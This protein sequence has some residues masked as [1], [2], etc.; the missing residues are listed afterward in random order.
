MFLTPLVIDR[1]TAV[2][3]IVK[4]DYRTAVIF[5]KYGISY[6]CG[7]KWPLEMVCQ[8]MEL[9]TE[10][11]IKELQLAMRTI[12][13]SNQLNFHGWP[14]DF[15][16][17]YIINIHHHFLKH[18]LPGLREMLREFAE[19]HRNKYSYITEVETRFDMLA[20]QLVLAMKREEE[21]LFPYIRQIEHAKDLEESY[22]PLMVRT[23][24]KPVEKTL[25]INHTIIV[26]VLFSLRELTTNYTPPEK[27]CMSHKVIL[28]KLHELDNDILHHLHLEQTILFPRMAAIEKQ[29]LGN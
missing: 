12:P 25:D 18:E 24:R 27:A 22:A 17:D 28:A 11:I 13:V 8:S 21:N 3:D 1:K 14:V 5:R 6:C 7:G 23:L 16:I 2:T 20:A 19:E 4:R 15:M 26:D 29:I 10:E 9:D